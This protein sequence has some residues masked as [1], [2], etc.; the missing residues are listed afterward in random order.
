MG[1][2][3]DKETG[4]Q[5]EGEIRIGSVS[6]SSCL[7]VRPSQPRAQPIGD[8]ALQGAARY[9]IAQIHAQAHQRLCHLWT[10]P[11]QHHLRLHQVHI[12]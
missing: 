1:L 12:Y 11:R 5:G 3:V 9:D 7:P 4:R 10:Q 2:T 6:L 8:P